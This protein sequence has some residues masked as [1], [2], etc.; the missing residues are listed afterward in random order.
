MQF[1]PFDKSLEEVSSNDLEILR[2]VSEGWYIEYKSQLPKVRDLAK[3]LASFANQYG[4]WLFL[5]IDE[6]PGSH[7]A[8][9][10]TGVES[11]TVS[12]VLEKLR[13]A[14]KD[15]VRPQILFE[16]RVISGPAADL[17]LSPRRSVVVVR[18]PEGANTPYIHNDGKIYIRIA[19]SSS[20]IPVT[21]KTTFDLLYRRGEDKRAHLKTLVE[22]SPEVSDYEKGNC[23]L[24]LSIL[25]DPYQT[26]G[27]R[28]YGT[29]SDFVA[30][31]GG[32]TIPF[33]NVF[34]TNDG[35][36]ARQVKSNNRFA[37][38]FTWEF[39]RNCNSFVT[40][41]IPTLPIL[42]ADSLFGPSEHELWAQYSI[43]TRF[44]SALLSKGLE[45]SR[46]LNLNLM[47]SLVGA[48]VSRHRRIVGQSNI[49]GPFYIKA[50]IEN[51]WRAIPFVDV[52]KYLTHVQNF[53]FPVV[54]DSNLMVPAGTSLDTF[55]I[56]PELE[57]IPSESEIIKYK[58]P[59]DI[60]VRIMQAFGIPG[61]LLEESA[62]ELLN[63]SILESERNRVH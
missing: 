56:S 10:F 15:V 16:H 23:Y 37:R 49:K 30:V 19:D 55:V 1:T 43:G 52:D 58:G 5:G 46:I 27:H 12:D 59:V 9:V 31:M 50:R 22:R 35:F 4:G 51:A 26:L 3:S 44:R 47:L 38:L 8:G 54:Q 39:S 13:N 45:T 18:V 25:S 60:W 7:T 29:Y 21:D 62:M 61:E 53:D 24:H 63:S 20:P 42:G 2:D 17:G 32:I 36:I 33:D 28:Y 34:T 11:E 57:W 40:M 14:A 48:L 6:N 41:P